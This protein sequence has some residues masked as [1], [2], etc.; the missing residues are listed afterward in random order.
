MS[1]DFEDLAYPPEGGRVKLIL[2]GLVVPGVIAYFA[3]RAWVNQQAYWPGSRGSGMT[4]RGEAAQALAMAYMSIG[5]FMHF[6]WCWGLM[7]AHRTFQIGTVCS[8][9]VFLGCLIYALCAL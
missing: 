7:S 3:A 6:R 9:L 2:L 4:V 8:L 1:D 5:A